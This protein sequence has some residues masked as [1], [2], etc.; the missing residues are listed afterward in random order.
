M[1]AGM[2]WLVA[3]VV[4]GCA[5]SASAPSMV[6]KPRLPDGF[7]LHVH[8]KW[9]ELDVVLVDALGS[10]DSLDASG[11][12]VAEI[13]GC[14]RKYIEP[15]ASTDEDAGQDPG[16]TRFEFNR[17]P[18]WPL[19]LWWRSENP[20]SVSL[21][22]RY[23]ISNSRCMVTDRIPSAGGNRLGR[24]KIERIVGDGPCS[25]RIVRL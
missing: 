22:A 7:T 21:I 6:Q 25:L 24:L 9:G 16:S 10:V 18:D 5:C 20:D 17:S 13:K 2:R 4:L 8:G 19:E 1:K 15:E 14:S 23:T 12:H 3:G 11:E